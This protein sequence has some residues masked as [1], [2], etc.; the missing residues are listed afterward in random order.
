MARTTFTVRSFVAVVVVLACTSIG[1]LLYILDG[2]SDPW[3][4]D[5]YALENITDYALLTDGRR[6][7]SSIRTDDD[8]RRRGSGITESYVISFDET[9]VDQF[10]VR[11]NHSGLGHA[12]WVM[13]VDG[14]SQKNLDLY[15]GLIKQPPLNASRFDRNDMQQKSEYAS[16]HA[17][18]CYLS[19]WNLLRSLDHRPPELRPDLYFVFE[20]DS[21]CVPDARERALDAARRLPPNWD[22]LFLGGKPFARLRGAILP[23]DSTADEITRAICDGEFGVA[24]GPLAPDGTRNLS[25]SQPF[26]STKYILNTNA[27]V[28]NPRR[29][30]H[31]AQ[32]LRPDRYV[33]VDVRL[34]D[35]SAANKLNVYMTGE[36]LCLQPVDSQWSRTKSGVMYESLPWEGYYWFINKTWDFHWGKMLMDECVGMY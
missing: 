7:R 31:V 16:P 26:W 2:R 24:D 36:M 18:G 9:K 1:P 19:H 34:A 13:A 4:I 6:R 10:H 14:F 20:D 27:F 12:L 25:A 30:G 32:M 23:S 8:A 22:L 11:N 33:P 35:Q 21:S 15:G 17:V 5:Q 3:G 28:V 29:A